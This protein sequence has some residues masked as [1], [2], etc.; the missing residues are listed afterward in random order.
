MRDALKR[1]YNKGYTAH[2]KNPNDKFV[3]PSDYSI[4]L[5]AQTWDF[6]WFGDGNEIV[7]EF[8]AAGLQVEWNGSSV[9]TIRVFI[10]AP[11]G[12]IV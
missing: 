8:R 11:T 7:D 12:G 4:H 10:P 5:D 3:R 6:E 1:L 2:P 9:R